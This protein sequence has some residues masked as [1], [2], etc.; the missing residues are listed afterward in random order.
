MNKVKAS[1]FG[2]EAS[3]LLHHIADFPRNEKM[4]EG[5]WEQVTGTADET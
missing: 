1:V 5:G 3:A 4:T 2:N